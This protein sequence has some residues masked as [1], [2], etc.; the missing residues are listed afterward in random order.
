MNN[1]D[2]SPNYKKLYEIVRKK[3]Q[4]NIHFSYGNFDETYF[5]LRV[6]ETAKIIIEE[7]KKENKNIKIKEQ[8]ILVASI[9]HDIGKIK[10]NTKRIFDKNGIK[11]NFK[12]EWYKHPKLSVLIAKKILKKEGY[13]EDFIN[14]VLYLIENHAERELKNK[15]LELEIIQDADIISDIGFAGFIRAFLY[16]GRFKRSVIDSINFLENKYKTLNEECINL[17]ISKNIAK[18]EMEIQKNLTEEIFKEIDSDLL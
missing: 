15:S 17:K 14:E 13:S 1:L 6:Y 18:K 4:K 7:I 2:I 3:Y 5:S 12:K 11:E 8:Q 9:L 16:A 10:L